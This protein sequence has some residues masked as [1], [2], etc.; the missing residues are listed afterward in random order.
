MYVTAPR[1]YH[2]STYHMTHHELDHHY[3]DDHDVT[4]VKYHDSRVLK[5]VDPMH[6]SEF[7]VTDRSYNI[8]HGHHPSHHYYNN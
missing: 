1:D 4:P 6:P 8:Y 7:D 2:Y 5:A 3:D